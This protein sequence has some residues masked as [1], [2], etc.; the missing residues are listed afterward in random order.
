MW[1]PKRAWQK[2]VRTFIIK[3]F[4]TLVCNPYEY[5]CRD[6]YPMILIANK[7]DLDSARVVSREEGLNLAHRLRV[8]V[9]YSLYMTM[10]ILLIHRLRLC[11]LC[12]NFLTCLQRKHQIFEKQTLMSTD[13]VF[14]C[15]HSCHISAVPSYNMF[16]LFHYW[17]DNV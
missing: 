14:I 2:L 9:L 12:E 11:T 17:K 6:D 7:V 1:S 3:M 8:R 15:I 16:L 13:Y 4:T 5:I 10:T